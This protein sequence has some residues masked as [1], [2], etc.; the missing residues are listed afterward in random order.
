MADTEN[1]YEV[2]VIGAGPAGL[3]AASEA[4]AGGAHTVLIDAAGQFGGQYWRHADEQS[5]S[6]D[7]AVWHHGWKTYTGLASAVDDAISA[8]KLQY[9][10]ASHVIAAEAGSPFSLSIAPV[11]ESQP[12][13]QGLTQI[14]AHTVV[15]CPG[16][17][18]R[19][20]PVPG[21]TLP[22]VMAA[23]GIQAF[24]KTQ[25]I[26]PGQR[27][28]LGGTGPF[29]LSAAASVL[30][31]GAEVAAI[32]ESSDLT[33][34]VPRGVSAALVPSKGKEGA[35]Y[36]ALLARHR[37]PYF[38]RRAVVAIHGDQRATAV[39]TA[40]LN[41]D[42]KALPGTERIIEDVDL[43][44]LGWGFVPQSELVVQLGAQ[45]FRDADGS[46][47]AEVDKDQQSSVP[48]LYLAGE[49]TG[50]AGATAAVAEGRI[51]GRQ[52]AG[53]R[54]GGR[55]PRSSA[56]IKDRVLRRNHRLFAQAMHRAHPLPQQWPE[57]LT[58]ETVICR[59]EEVPWQK[60]K[61]AIDS[62]SAEEPRGLKGATRIGMGWCQGR[63]CGQAAD[64]LASSDS[65]DVAQ[66]VARRGPAIPVSLR[67]LAGESGRESS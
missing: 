45:M 8:G 1:T 66:A 23:G 59:C 28:V 4:A 2:A 41:R 37:V 13:H 50:V 60:T 47:V 36:I 32:C 62:L 19:Q 14:R 48:G 30:Q 51:A 49:I 65:A 54:G 24:I 39:S 9:L 57:W 43:V 6:E 25:G 56:D 53:L 29:L 17:Y 38:R 7:P 21:W 31:A 61:E 46:L 20:L 58:D 3:A 12:E 16:A 35:E 10:P 27:V 44:G 63:M 40:R 33:G 18:D 34:W 5:S 52:V 15:L 42:G 67:A 64:C 22:G 26:S 55:P 11:P